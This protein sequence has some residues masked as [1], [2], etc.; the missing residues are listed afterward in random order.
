MYW[1]ADDCKHLHFR[2]HLECWRLF[3]TA[4]YSFHAP[5][6]CYSRLVLYRC[7]SGIKVL[8]LAQKNS[9]NLSR[10]CRSSHSL[11]ADLAT[12]VY[13]SQA[14]PVTLQ[15]SS[16]RE[17]ASGKGFAVFRFLRAF[18]MGCSLYYIYSLVLFSVFDAPAASE[19][20]SEFHSLSLVLYAACCHVLQLGG[21]CQLTVICLWIAVLVI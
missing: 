5:P 3:R 6:H 1:N 20:L 21:A 2:P 13:I 4:S 17:A 14:A 12:S 16:L 9:C 10:A 18:G 19:A 8:C 11:R 7:F 15:L